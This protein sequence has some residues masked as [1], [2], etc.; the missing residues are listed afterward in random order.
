MSDVADSACRDAFSGWQPSLPPPTHREF[1]PRTRLPGGP[2]KGTP[3]DPATDPVQS[4]LID[5]L[6]SG[7]WARIYWS[8]PPQ[9]GGKCFA[10]GTLIR[11][12]NGSSIPVECI[13]VGMRLLGGIGECNTVTSLSSGHGEMFTISP[14]RFQPFTVNGEHILVLRRQLTGKIVKLTVNEYLRKPAWFKRQHRLFKRPNIGGD[15]VPSVSPYVIGAWIGDG[16]T[17]FTRLH[18][19]D[20]EIHAEFSRQA[21]LMGHW[22]QFTRA[23]KSGCGTTTARLVAKRTG[24]LSL[25]L[26]QTCGLGKIKRMPD[27]WEQWSV[28]AREELLSGLIDTDGCHCHGR[29]W[30]VVS[31]LEHLAQGYQRLA[32]SLGLASRV[33][34]KMVDGTPYWR[35]RISG[36]WNERMRVARKRSNETN[37]I[38]SRENISGFNVT[39]IGHGD[40]YGFTLDGDRTCCLDD[41]TITHNTQCAVIV[42]AMR[43]ALCLRATVGYGL[44]TLHDLDRGWQTKVAPTIRDAGL[45]EYLPQQGPGSRGGRPPSVTFEDPAN[46]RA[47]LGSF[48]F[49]AGGAKQVTC[50]VIVVDEADSWRTADGEPRW[51]DLEDVWSRAD[52]F[53][54]DAIRIAVGTVEVDDPAR[55]IVLALVNEHGTGHRLHARCPHCGVYATLE[56]DAFTYDYRTIEGGSG[57]DTAHAVATA[58]YS[59][60]SCGAKWSNDDRRK[61]LLAARFAAKGQTVDAAGIIQGPAPTATALGLR[62][63]AL[64]SI[65]TTLGAIAE[66]HALARYALDTHGNHEP[67]RKFYR[68]QRV[69]GYL[70]DQQSDAE[71]KETPHTHRTLAQRS[72]ITAWATVNEDSDDGKLWSRY[73][74]A[75]TPATVRIITAAIDVQRNRLYCVL[76]GLDADRRTYDLAWSIERA[77]AGPDGKEP[78]PWSAGELAETLT[79]AADWL[80]DVSG[81]LFRVGVVDVS[82]GVTQGEVAEWLSAR[83]KWSAIQGEDHLPAIRQD[84]K[85]QPRTPLICWDTQWRNGMGSYRVVTALAQQT[86]SDAYRIQ[87]DQ[88]GAALLPGPLRPG[89]AYLRHLTAVGWSTTPAGRRIWGPIKGSGRWD[90]FDGRAYS[91]AVALALRV[92]DETPPA[93]APSAPDAFNDPF[94]RRLR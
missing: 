81:P 49:L 85:I 72:E 90:Y 2:L 51:S 35:A 78:P 22:C 57:A 20:L 19:N 59:C 68:Y 4:W 14:E 32:W 15:V 53:Q 77:R 36:K 58:A 54:S 64:D 79:R 41:G 9:V 24:T 43:A 26:R 28:D 23:P 60:K 66:K 89:N 82:D 25:Y 55:S 13:S 37:S 52:S 65:L 46:N 27:G 17:G 84:G 8:A 63:H 42:P 31:K 70:G 61:A 62:T 38:D 67:M 83:P 44:P 39:P 69:E 74:A 34:V 86:I 94:L 71:A 16:D 33:G 91:T 48:I 47:P 76:T 30:E 7:R 88:P 80:E 10:K 6:D 45:G 56:W 87:H 5:Q 92:T 12:E 29:S 93:E 75:T 40:Y 18:G 73:S 11:L 50:R 3:Y 21:E 1:C